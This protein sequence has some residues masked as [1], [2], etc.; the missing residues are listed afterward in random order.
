[1]KSFHHQALWESCNQPR[2]LKFAGI[3]RIKLPQLFYT[4][5]NIFAGIK[6][7][8]PTS[9][10]SR[11]YY[12]LKRLPPISKKMLL[13]FISLERTDDPCKRGGG[14]KQV[15]DFSHVQI[16]SD[17]LPLLVFISLERK[18]EPCK[19]GGERRSSILINVFL[20]V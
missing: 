13:V 5:N 17:T 11:I 9:K 4:S 3:F 18:N 2:I 20:K 19:T 15:C 14:R 7:P 12:Q 1:M 6:L 16:Q 10:K 8:P